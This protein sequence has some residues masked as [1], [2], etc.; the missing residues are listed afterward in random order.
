MALLGGLAAAAFFATATLCSSRS[1]RML[2]PSSVLAW[3]M[4]TGLL[5]LLPAL[6]LVDVPSV[7]AGEVGWLLV[8]GG[9]NVAGL[10]LAYSALRRGKVGVVAPVLSTEGAIAAVAAVASG[11]RL[12][13]AAAWLLPPIAVGVALAASGPTTDVPTAP[14]PTGP[15]TRPV[16]LAGIAAGC[17]GASLYAT[18]R[19]SAD[20]PVA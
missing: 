9:G 8:S 7:D 14:G 19:A 13:V 11:E 3:V 18:S 17:F 4:V 12:A 15:G 2:P 16:L 20:L 10:L 5:A 1:A 6:A